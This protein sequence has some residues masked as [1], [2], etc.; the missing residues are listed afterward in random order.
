MLV[1]W[2]LG[3][4]VAAQSV[5]T[6][7]NADS[8]EARYRSLIAD[9]LAAYE[10][11]RFVVALARFEEAYALRPNAR[12]MRGVALVR[13]ELGDHVQT[14]RAVDVALA[15]PID[16]LP[17]D[18]RAQ[19]LEVRTRA[20]ARLERVVVSLEPRGAT[21]RIDGKDAETNERGELWLAPGVHR[22]EARQVGFSVEIR[23][24]EA[25]PGGVRTLAI[26]LAPVFL[27]SESAPEPRK[28]STWGWGS[29]AA[30]GLVGSGVSIWQSV[31]LSRVLSRCQLGEAR[32][33]TCL[34]E[35]EIRVRRGVAIGGALLSAGLTIGSA[36]PLARSLLRSKER[37][38]ALSAGCS[39]SSAELGCRGSFTW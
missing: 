25:S 7:E 17:E 33:A 29:A 9:A 36:F 15:C 39:L 3:S 30:V 5:P 11:G 13:F 6:H 32:G 8:D 1:V 27:H 20:A 19:L 38:T 24:I 4:S 31:S 10:D 37:S 23:A 2:P 14:L 26:T 12:A 16:P 22:V 35:T 34:N 28:L 18:L 21:L